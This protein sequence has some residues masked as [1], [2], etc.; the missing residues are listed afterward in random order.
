[1]RSLCLGHE[2]L[3][4]RSIGILHIWMLFFFLKVPHLTARLVC[5]ALYEACVCLCRELDE[6]EGA[7]ELAPF[8]FHDLKLCNAWFSVAYFLVIHTAPHCRLQNTMKFSDGWNDRPC[9]AVD[10]RQKNSGVCCR[11]QSIQLTL[12]IILSLTFWVFLILHIFF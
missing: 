10:W 2:V 8:L 7:R 3:W 5:K 9:E 12:F 6:L 1:M 4:S 11:W